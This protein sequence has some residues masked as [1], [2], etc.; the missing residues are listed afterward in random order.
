MGTATNVLTLTSGAL[1]FIGSNDATLTGGQ[2]GASNAELIV[3]QFGSCKLEG[4]RVKLATDTERELDRAS[5][6]PNA[7]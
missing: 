2:A 7:G 1:Q 3:H 4:L 6:E 5:T